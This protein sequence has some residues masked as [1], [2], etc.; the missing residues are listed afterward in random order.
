MPAE[1]RKEMLV[2]RGPKNYEQGV[3]QQIGYTSLLSLVLLNFRSLVDI[4]RH[5]APFR[6]NL[7][8][9]FINLD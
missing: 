8:Q 1:L 6:K 5:G 2:C 7:L 3:P 4:L 9:G